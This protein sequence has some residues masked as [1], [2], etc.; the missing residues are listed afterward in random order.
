[1]MVITFSSKYWYYC[2][3]PSHNPKANSN[4]LA[5]YPLL[6]V[7]SKSICI[8][9][10]LRKNTSVLWLPVQISSCS[11]TGRVITCQHRHFKVVCRFLILDLSLVPDMSCNRI[12]YPC[13]R[14]VGRNEVK[15]WIRNIRDIRDLPQTSVQRI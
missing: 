6:Q 7:C 2:Y 11:I 10:D 12:D 4:P 14:L 5:S 9:I 13:V 8:H 1:M 3:I 15:N